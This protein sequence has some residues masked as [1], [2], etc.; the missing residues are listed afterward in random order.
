MNEERA[1]LLSR[2]R[3]ASPCPASW[4]AMEGDE[5]VRFCRL[6]DLHVYNVSELTRAEAGSLV[7]RTEG[8]LCARLYRRADG[9]VLTKDC[10][11]GLR[12]ARRRAGRA[13]GAAF[14]AV[15]SLCGLA[16]GQ[17]KSKRA[18]ACESGSAK[19][20]RT[21]KPGKGSALKGIVL[22]PNGAFIPGASVVLTDN[23]TK[24][25][26]T[27]ATTDEGK[28]EFAAL[29]AGVY[30]VEA[31][32]P[33]FKR[34]RMTYLA[35]AADEA[36]GLDLTLNVDGEEVMVGVIGYSDPMQGN[37]NGVTTF[38]PERITKL[39]YP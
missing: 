33:G 28:F 14:A 12:A 29:P 23:K 6:C 24:K 38:E 5:R 8:R 16:F 26:L 2:V 4:E 10:P 36:V 11:T 21:V 27:A 37:G 9:T 3:V 7:S 25:K 20:S 31:A 18:D 13:A 34:L 30:Q 19:V 32:L 15:L 35:V 22:D 39:P 17:G 1:D